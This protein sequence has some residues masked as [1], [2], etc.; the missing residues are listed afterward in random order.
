MP[1]ESVVAEEKEGCEEGV[2]EAGVVEKRK[3]EGEEWCL[4]ILW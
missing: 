2:L 1:G 4:E 3:V